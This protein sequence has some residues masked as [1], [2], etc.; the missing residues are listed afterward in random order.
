M[1]WPIMTSQSYGKRRKKHMGIRIECQ[2]LTPQSRVLDN[3]SC[4]ADF[5]AGIGDLVGG[6]LA[7]L[8][9]SNIEVPGRSARLSTLRVEQIRR[10]LRVPP[11]PALSLISCTRHPLHVEAGA[12]GRGAAPLCPQPPH[13][14]FAPETGM[15]CSPDFCRVR[16]RDWTARRS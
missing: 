9:V 14:S 7:R 8:P 11:L 15:L 5:P 12:A 6:S 10:F 4:S 1:V 13:Y 3:C 2:R 16:T